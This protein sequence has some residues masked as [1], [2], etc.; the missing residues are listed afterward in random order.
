M[1]RHTHICFMISIVDSSLVEMVSSGE[2][3]YKDY[4]VPTLSLAQQGP[5]SIF[6][7]ELSQLTVSPPRPPS[8]HFTCPV[9]AVTPGI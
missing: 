8:Q 2:T 4:G 3:Y 9:S 7:I 6:D 5:P 1:T